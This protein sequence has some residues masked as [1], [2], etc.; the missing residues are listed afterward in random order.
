MFQT[1]KVFFKSLTL[2][3]LLGAFVDLKKRWED[4]CG[5]KELPD[6]VGFGNA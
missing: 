6:W 4:V 5:E 1:E 2:V 3:F